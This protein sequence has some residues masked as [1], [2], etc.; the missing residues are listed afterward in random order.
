MASE[1]K[2]GRPVY[3][4]CF[5][6]VCVHIKK[7]DIK[8]CTNTGCGSTRSC[9]PRYGHVCFWCEAYRCPDHGELTPFVSDNSN[10]SMCDECVKIHPLTRCDSCNGIMLTSCG[11]PCRFRG[12]W[13]CNE[14]FY[15]RTGRH[16]PICLW[17]FI[18]KEPCSICRQ[19][20]NAIICF[21]GAV[22]R[23][24]AIEAAKRLPLAPPPKST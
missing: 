6:G 19:R 17:C 9:I 23:L 10:H 22:L 15:Q 18:D 11:E 21:G 14:M 4:A 5:G 20:V 24:D 8:D 12:F 3:C 16:F 7:C 2:L 1:A 13:K